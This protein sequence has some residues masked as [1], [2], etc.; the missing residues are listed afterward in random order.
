MSNVDTKLFTVAGTSLSNGSYK[1]RFAQDVAGRVKMLERYGDTDVVLVELPNPMTKTDAIAFLQEA[2]PVGVNL[3]AL[4]SKETSLVVRSTP[5]ATKATKTDEEKAAAKLAKETAKAAK[6]FERAAA[7][8]AKELARAN[9]KIVKDA[10]KAT[11]AAAKAAAKPV[12]PVLPT[13]VKPVGPEPIEKRPVAADSLVTTIVNSARKGHSIR[14]KAQSALT[15]TPQVA[16]VNDV[17]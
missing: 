10:E 8:A 16:T 3:E 6:V 17:A 9:A 1:A 12:A 5:R 14:A 2:K 7:K 4:A 15:S 13:P 11:K